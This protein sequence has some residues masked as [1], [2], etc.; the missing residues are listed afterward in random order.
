MHYFPK[1]SYEMC[2]LNCDPCLTAYN[3]GLTTYDALGI[4]SCLVSTEEMLSLIYE[5]KILSNHTM[6]S[7]IPNSQTV[8]QVACLVFIELCAYKDLTLMY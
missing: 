4:A 1:G 8:T 5:S 3:S 6:V 7:H 2:I